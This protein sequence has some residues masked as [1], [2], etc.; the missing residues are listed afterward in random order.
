MVP[1][2]RT[3]A[4]EAPI[5]TIVTRTGETALLTATKAAPDELRL[6]PRLTAR[7]C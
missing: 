3:E 7:A 4:I 2:A 1:A 5:G 6:I